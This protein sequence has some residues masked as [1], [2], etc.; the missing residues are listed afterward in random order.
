MSFQKDFFVDSFKFSLSKTHLCP[1][2]QSAITIKHKNTIILVTANF[3]KHTEAELTASYIYSLSVNYLERFYASAKIPSSFTRREIR[4]TD[5]EILIS[6]L[7]DRHLK[8]FLP[9]NLSGQ[10]QIVAKVL[11]C[12]PQVMHLEV[13]AANAAT[14]ALLN[15]GVPL[16]NIPVL[17]QAKVA[18]NKYDS[19]KQLNIASDSTEEY[20]LKI[21][22]SWFDNKLSMLELEAKKCSCRSSSYFPTTN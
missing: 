21:L 2:S 3:V 20:D 8:P 9:K 6:R 11:S 12:D 1:L 15:L 19:G 16:Q 13:M 18:V 7:I 22:A 14:A 4:S 5:R 10:I 17:A